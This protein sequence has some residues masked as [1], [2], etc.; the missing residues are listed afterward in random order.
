MMK[1]DPHGLPLVKGVA[2]T[3]SEAIDSQRSRPVYIFL[4]GI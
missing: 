3:V 1:A 2:V 4:G